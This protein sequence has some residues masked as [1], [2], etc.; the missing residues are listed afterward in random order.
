MVELLTPQ[1][2]HIKS[3]SGTSADPYDFKDDI[4]ATTAADV[5]SLCNAQS[6]FELDQ[7]LSKAY[8]RNA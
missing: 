4:T 1:Q 8:L 3:Q 2:Q 6:S 5:D 7:K